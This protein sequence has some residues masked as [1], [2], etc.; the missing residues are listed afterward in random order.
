M[1]HYCSSSYF[2]SWSRDSRNKTNVEQ[3]SRVFGK[4]DLL[5]YPNEY[6]FVNEE[7]QNNRYLFSTQDLDGKQSISCNHWNREKGEYNH[8]GCGGINNPTLHAEHDHQ[9]HV[10]VVVI[11]G[12]E[13]TLYKNPEWNV[14]D[15]NYSKLYIDDILP[16]NRN[17]HDVTLVDFIENHKLSCTKEKKL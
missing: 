10:W 13:V 17:N 5:Q 12:S 6:D 2:G 14:I 16:K 1:V 11:D 3:L 4:I 7:I 8:M 9:P 15:K